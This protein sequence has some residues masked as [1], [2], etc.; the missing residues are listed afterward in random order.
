LPRFQVTGTGR[1]TRRKR[2]RV[3]DVANEDAARRNADVDGLDVLEVAELPPEPP[4]ESQLAY[5]RDLGINIPAGVSREEISDLIGVRTENDKP[6]S[7]DLLA[8]ATGYGAKVTRYTG[9]KVAFQRIFEQLTTTPDRQQDLAGW[10][11]YRVY[12]ELV[13][14]APGSAISSP[15]DDAIQTIARQLAS[16]PD[17]IQSIRRYEG[18]D[19]VWFGQWTSPGGTL[20]E[21]GSN[22]TIAYK[23]AAE[24]LRPVVAREKAQEQARIRERHYERPEP[25]TPVRAEPVAAKGCLTVLVLGIGL[26]A[27]LSS[28]AVALWPH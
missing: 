23:K 22:R 28:A 5:A 7:A 15:N 26:V 11:A 6:A 19:L 12:R 21:G 3:Y 2:K 14:G 27:V 1:D 18:R 10:F 17:V 20:H 25:P 8:L 16:Q 13:H 9:K 24:L 4:T